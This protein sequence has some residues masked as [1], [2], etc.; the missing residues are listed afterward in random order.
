[1]GGYLLIVKKRVGKTFVFLW[2][3]VGFPFYNGEPL[4]NRGFPSSE[5]DP[6]DGGSSG[7]PIDFAYKMADFLL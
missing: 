6:P 7:I 1:M 3:K 2:R 4:E 5:I